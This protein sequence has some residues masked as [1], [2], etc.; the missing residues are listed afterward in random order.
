MNSNF[1]K[2]IILSLCAILLLS[3]VIYG[4]FNQKDTEYSKGQNVSSST[5]SALGAITSVSVGGKTLKTF[6]ADTPESRELGLS[7]RESLKNDEVMLFVFDKPG[8]H[9]IW[10]K[11]M[12]FAIDI[13]WLDNSGRIIYLVEDARPDTFPKI[14]TPNSPAKYVLESTA[15]FAR[16]N[17]L[18]IGSEFYFSKNN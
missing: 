11:D 16:E 2:K 14:F 18:K 6:L 13:F 5:P 8:M 10:M 3:F 4:G 12:K 9:G 15:S 1:S 17:S 7:G